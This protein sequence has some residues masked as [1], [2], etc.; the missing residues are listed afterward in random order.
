MI[1][2]LSIYLDPSGHVEEGAVRLTGGSNH[3]S[4]R[5]EIFHSGEWVTVCDSG[6]DIN[7]ATVVCRQLG[8]KRIIIL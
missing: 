2:L 3:T 8:F 6:W 1:H 7:D 4:G 5:V